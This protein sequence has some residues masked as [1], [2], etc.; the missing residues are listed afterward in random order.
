[1]N[2]NWHFLPSFVVQVAGAGLVASCLG[3]KEMG[4][5][6]VVGRIASLNPSHLSLQSMQGFGVPKQTPFSKHRPSGFSPI[7]LVLSCFS[8]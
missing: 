6:A 3:I 4:E 7:C 2:G 1:M 8:N 5:G